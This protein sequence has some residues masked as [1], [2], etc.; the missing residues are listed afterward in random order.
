M[1]RRKNQSAKM[2]KLPAQV[3]FEIE[4]FPCISAVLAF[5]PAPYGTVVGVT[6]G[7]I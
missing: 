1:A 3:V 7:Q 4:T 5:L 6:D 2:E